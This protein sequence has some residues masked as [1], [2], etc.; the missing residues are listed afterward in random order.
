MKKLMSYVLL[1]LSLT[2]LEYEDKKA[3]ALEDE[4]AIQQQIR[5]EK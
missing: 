5:Y 3:D 2:T 4:R 1:V